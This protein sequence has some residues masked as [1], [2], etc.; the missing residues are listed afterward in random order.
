MGAVP[1][2]VGGT[3]PVV[4]R[5]VAGGYT[6]AEVG[7]ASADAGVDDIGLHPAPRLRVGVAVVERQRALI[8]AVETPR[9]CRRL[10]GRRGHDAVRLDEDDTRVASQGHRGG[11]RQPHRE[12]G[13]HVAVLV[14]HGS[15]CSPSGGCYCR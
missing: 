7:V 2:A 14:A 10:R 1:V 5:G 8:H 4:D 12:S 11:S 15:A 3:V 13:E 6:A 9:W